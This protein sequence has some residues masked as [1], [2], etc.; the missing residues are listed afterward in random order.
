M[1]RVR[2]MPQGRF[3]T[4][5][6]G[7][8]RLGRM[9]FCSLLCGPKTSVNAIFHAPTAFLDIV[10]A[11]LRRTKTRYSLGRFRRK[12]GAAGRSDSFGTIGNFGSA[13]AQMLAAVGPRTP[14]AWCILPRLPRP[15][16]K[17][18]QMRTVRDSGIAFSGKSGG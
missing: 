17:R 14:G 7:G 18:G 4:R 3:W 8:C 6:A 11:I 15:I 1:G 16:L 9:V 2:C 13:D 12:L 10:T 5:R